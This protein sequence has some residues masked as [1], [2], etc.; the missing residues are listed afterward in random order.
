[1]PR[2]IAIVSSVI[3]L[4]SS[5]HASQPD[6]THVA[7][8]A[9]Y[10]ELGGKGGMYG[11]YFERLISDQLGVT[12]GFSRWSFEFLSVQEVTVIPVFITWYPVGS[13]ARLYVDVGGEYVH[14]FASGALFSG[15]S[16]SG[17]FGVVGTGLAVRAPGGGIFFKVGPLLF[18]GGSS[19]EL[20]G[21]VSLG[22]TI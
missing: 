3:L 13:S 10:G 4:A 20:W 15:S 17:A 9:L 19:V 2:V 8:N 18:V 21:N 22:C 16:G 12:I 1:M 6:N 7:R 5:S 11:V 14:A